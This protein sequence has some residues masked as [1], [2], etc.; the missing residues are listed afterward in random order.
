MHAS[1]TR[2]IIEAE[3]IIL[4]TSMVDRWHCPIDATPSRKRVNC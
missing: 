4:S 1:T 3:L 2:I